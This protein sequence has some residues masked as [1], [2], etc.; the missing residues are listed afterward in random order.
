[1]DPTTGRGCLGITV[2][3]LVLLYAGVW[4]AFCSFGRC[5]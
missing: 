1:M 2:L 5:P 3:T 4:L